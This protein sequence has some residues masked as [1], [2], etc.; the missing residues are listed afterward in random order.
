MKIFFRDTSVNRLNRPLPIDS[1]TG[2]Y[3]RNFFLIRLKEERERAKR[4]ESPFSLLIVDVIGISR[5]LNKK[6]GGSARIDQKK[7]IQALVKQSRKIDIKGWLD[8]KRV[9]VLM[10]E[11]KNS[12]VLEFEEK[13]CR[14]IRRDL[15]AAAKVDLKKFIQVSTF[16]DGSSG[17]NGSPVDR[18][19]GQGGR[20]NEHD[21]GVYA[22]ITSGDFSFYLKR[23]TKRILDIVGSILGII[24]TSPLMLIIAGLIKLTSPGPVL[25]RQ[26]RVGFLGRRFTFLKFRSM[27]TNAD[28]TIHET[29]I[30][31][32]INGQNG[33]INRGT[34]AQPLYKM[35]DDP[36][37][38][39]LGWFLRKTSVDEL[40]QLFNILKGEMSLVGPRPPIPYEMEKYR[41]WHWG[42]VFEVKPGLTGLWQVSGRS[43]MGFDDMVRLDLRYAD[44]WSIWLDIK[45]ILKT[46]RAV[47][48]T[49][50]AY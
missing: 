42:R 13:I 28:Q 32:L 43:K 33:K 1:K 26:E 25:F 21:N 39:P 35:N 20:N 18:D 15:P 10:P 11:T 8:P 22:D 14:R 50:G 34:T 4:I 9:G 17:G 29:Y 24:I 41:L 30:A 45:I 40:P 2:L 47:L 38:T 5:A 23:L 16:G 3:S 12:G 49:E 36:R 48:S 27:V 31:N 37:V 44:N 7:L 6:A 46:F 19:N